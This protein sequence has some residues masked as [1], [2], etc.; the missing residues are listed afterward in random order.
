MATRS[1]KSRPAKMLQ[2]NIIAEDCP[3][4]RPVFL[5]T[6]QTIAQFK[7]HNFSKA[8]GPMQ[9][10][11]H[12]VWTAPDGRPHTVTEREDVIASGSRTPLVDQFDVQDGD[13]MYLYVVGQFD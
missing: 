9:N 3:T 10:Q 12:L 6:D 4:A 5:R 8:G 2:I 1:R 7:R 13:N 11:I